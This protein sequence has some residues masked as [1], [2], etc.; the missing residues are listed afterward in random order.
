ML[1][2]IL[3][4]ILIELGKMLVKWL[5]D[6]LRQK[7]AEKKIKK[8]TKDRI[9]VIKKIPDRAERMRRLNDLINN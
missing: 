1:A 2:K 6:Y 5:G 8:D 7:Q 9:D 3:P 4:T